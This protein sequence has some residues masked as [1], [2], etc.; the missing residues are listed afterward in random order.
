MNDESNSE[1]SKYRLPE[2]FLGCLLTLAVFSVGMLLTAGTWLTK[3]AAGFFTFALVIVG[4]L[5]AALFFVQLSLIRESLGPAKEAAKAAQAA[6]EALPTV[7]KAYVFIDPKLEWD[8]IPDPSFGISDSRYSVK[9]TLE[10]HGKTPAVIKSID[11]RLEVLSAPPDNKL[12]RIIDFLPDKILRAG[13]SFTPESSP[14]HCTV[15]QAT[16]VELQNDRSAIW[17]YGSVYYDDMFGKEHVTRFRCN[18]SEIL[19]VFVARGDAP[20]NERT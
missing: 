14:R 9:F 16:L 6:A 4:V 18:Q 7:E 10:N 5:Q 2:F 3:D 20:F 15:N 11:A 17:F 12:H 19:D 8:Q 1:R 13:E